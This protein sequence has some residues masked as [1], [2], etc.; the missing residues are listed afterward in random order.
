[1]KYLGDKINKALLIID[2][3][4]GSFTSATP[5]YN[6]QEVISK[7]NNLADIFRD[8]NYA[9]IYIQHDGTGTGVFEKNAGDWE[10]L[11]ELNINSTDILVD[12]YAND[13][14]YKSTLQSQLQELNI[15]E[16][17]LTG[18]ATDFC[19]ESTAQSALTKNYK[20]TMVADAHTTGER[21]HLSAQEV[22]EHYNWVWQH[23]LPTQGEIS[24][25]TIAQI[26]KDLP[27]SPPQ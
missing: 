24:V 8:L 14:F 5:R 25:K 20:V 26:I 9:V 13:A 22:I 17:W 10:V 18:C 4:K 27:Y 23:M 7:I 12:K 3:Q 2:M 15:K 16:L 1:M 6:T 11:D 19:V 21:P